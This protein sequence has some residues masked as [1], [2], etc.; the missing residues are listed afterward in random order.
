MPI[1]TEVGNGYN[2]AGLLR[3]SCIEIEKDGLLT[4]IR[5]HTCHLKG[6]GTCFPPFGGEVEQVVFMYLISYAILL[7]VLEG[8]CVL[9]VVS[10]RL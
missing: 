9:A 3:L 2:Q 4:G 6:K 8:T 10:G 1:W 5:P 7:Q